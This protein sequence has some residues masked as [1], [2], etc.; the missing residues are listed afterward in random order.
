MVAIEKQEQSETEAIQLRTLAD[1]EEYAAGKKADAEAYQIE[2]LS[3]AEAHRI[4]LTSEAELEAASAM[5]S[6]LE[7]Y[8]ELA[9]DYI[10]LLLTQ[11]LRENSKW[12]ISGPG[13]F[14]PTIEIPSTP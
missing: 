8:G 9:E 5:L 14:S 1:A 13:E 2:V 3:E 4:M 6:I 7:K 10:Q 11:E 12:I